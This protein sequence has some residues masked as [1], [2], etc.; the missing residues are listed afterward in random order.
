MGKEQ[1]YR[2]TS[3]E[4]S[5]QISVLAKAYITSVAHVIPMGMCLGEQI[6]GIFN[7]D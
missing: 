1:C 5:A 6:L 3:N 4:L 7:R 2:D